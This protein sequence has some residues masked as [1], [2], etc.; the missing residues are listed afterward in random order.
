MAFQHHIEIA[1]VAI[2]NDERAFFIE[3]GARIA[4]LRKEQDITQVQLA[5]SLGTSQQTITAYEGGRRR[6]PVSSLPK[7][8]RL[9]GVSIEELIG[10]NGRRGGKRGPASKLQQQ[11]EQVS[12]LPRAQQ[13]F[14]SQML[15]TVL[16]QAGR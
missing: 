6:V 9:L 4:H 1:T 7:L 11:L 2:S 8:A 13:K 5:E 15:D 3:L 16:Q 12:Q 10:D 14:V